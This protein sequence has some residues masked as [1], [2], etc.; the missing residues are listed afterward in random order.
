MASSAKLVALIIIGNTRRGL[1]LATTEEG[2]EVLEATTEEVLEATIEEVLGATTEEVL[3][4]TTEEVLGAT[5]MTV[6]MRWS[7]R[8][9]LCGLEGSGV[10]MRRLGGQ[11]EQIT[12]FAL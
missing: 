2:Q 8:G 3:G 11:R 6:F 10:V 1:K 5:A 12:A 9:V 4:A 7:K